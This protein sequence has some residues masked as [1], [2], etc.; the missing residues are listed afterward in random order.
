MRITIP[1][2]RKRSELVQTPDIE[3]FEQMEKLCIAHAGLGLAAIQVGVPVRQAVIEYSMHADYVSKNGYV[4]LV[5]GWYTQVGTKFERQI[6]GCLSIP[7]KR[8]VV[9]RY[10]DYI[11]RGSFYNFRTNVLVEKRL[12]L[13]KPTPFQHEIDHFFDVLISDRGVSCG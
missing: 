6:E 7:G 11:V 1:I 4:W 3:L 13:G 10:A 12:R 9:E 5:N 8:Y 2:E